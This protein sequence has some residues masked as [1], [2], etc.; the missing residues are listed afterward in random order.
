MATNPFD[1]YDQPSGNF[2]DK[3]DN[4]PK[5][6]GA[7]RRLADTGLAL[8]KGVVGVPEAA[9]GV[10]DLATNG[11]VGKAVENAGIRFKDAKD[12]LDTFRSDDQKAADAEVAK[13]EGFFPTVGT[14][15]QNPST[16]I[17]SAV[18]SAPSMIGGGV[19]SRGALGALKYVAPKTA[20]RI[21]AAEAAPLVASPAAK[22]AA[23]FAPI[24]AGALGE[25]VVAAGQNA[26]QVRQ[27]DPNG[28]LTP[29]QSAIL[30]ASGLLTGGISLASGK[31]ANKL[32]IGDVQTMLASGKLGTVGEVK[33][34]AKK[35]IARQ[36]GEGF[37]NEGVLQEL[38]QSYQEQVAQNIAQGKPWDEGAAKAGAQGMLAGG[39]TGA[40]G[41][42]VSGFGGKEAPT[43]TT[44]DVGGSA[45][46]GAAGTDPGI[47]P[48]APVTDPVTGSISG[49]SSSDLLSGQIP[50]FGGL[51]NPPQQ[52]I[53]PS[54]QMGINPTAG[55][56]S[57]AAIA[58]VL[59]VDAETLTP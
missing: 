18:E 33:A 1:Q 34:G 21:A 14:M 6:A 4:A 50:S 26:E 58:E 52:A 31:L 19:V 55:P 20:A 15:L 36:I 16:I 44:V 53:T 56:I 17:N 38:P 47:V 37:A 51:N 5:P 2:F 40:G 12:V 59:G 13:A 45:G 7:I 41:N 48:I 54:A 11:Q 32:G 3:F 42:V 25:G 10:A 28:T 27:E 24:A 57:A 29:Q 22:S 46:Q 9:V 35:G 23:T 8:A 30:G 43:P 49:I 39:L